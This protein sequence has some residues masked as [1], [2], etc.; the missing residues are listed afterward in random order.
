[1]RNFLSKG[2]HLAS[3][4]IHSK[5][6]AAAGFDCMQVVSAKFEFRKASPPHRMRHIRAINFNAE[7]EP[8]LCRMVTIYG[9]YMPLFFVSFDL[10]LDPKGT[11]LS[12]PTSTTFFLK[13][14]GNSCTAYLRV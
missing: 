13:R 2:S 4:L 11:G 3:L 9:S 5:I 14:K 7:A 1:M 10:F 6:D 12:V 8:E